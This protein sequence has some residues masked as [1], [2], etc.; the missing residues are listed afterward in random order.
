[1]RRLA[2]C[3]LTVFLF[4]PLQVQAACDWLARPDADVH[5]I[6]SSRLACLSD[7]Y[8]VACVEFDAVPRAAREQERL[9]RIDAMALDDEEAAH[10]R[11]R[12]LWLGASR[13][14]ACLAWGKPHRLEENSVNP[15]GESWFYGD[16]DVDV[17]LF[18]GNAIVEIRTLETTLRAADP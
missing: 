8:S 3:L 16:V 7:P 12:G 5:T 18:D 14:M 17:L 6:I 10:L 4:V 11:D 15:F 13:E 9:R 1:M 2:I